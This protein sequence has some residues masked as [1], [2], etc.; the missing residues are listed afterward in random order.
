MSGY[1]I[2]LNLKNR[3][4]A[5]VGGGRVAARKTA[6]LLAAGAAVTV[7]SP[8]LDRQL[9]RLYQEA[10]ID[11]FA[12]PY[13]HK[14]LHALQPVLVITATNDPAVN[15]Q[16]AADARLL[17]AWVNDVS[18]AGHS[19][20]SSLAVVEQ[21]PFQ[22]AIG[23]G[24][25]APALLQIVKKR[26]ETTLSPDLTTLGCWLAALRPQVRAVVSDQEKRRRVY[27]AIIAS[28][29]VDLLRQNKIL[30]ARSRFDEVV[31]EHLP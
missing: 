11:W 8:A 19:D 25:G 23:S 4:C 20:F 13:A 30:E 17:G 14:H 22:I 15:R 6:G 9:Q 5:I 3:P 18:G 31:G 29:V 10:Q 12:A 21:P 1:C 7:I 2:S 28:D 26:L 24:G 27:E 16:A